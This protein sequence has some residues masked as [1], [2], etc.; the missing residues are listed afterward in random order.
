M[1]FRRRGTCRALVAFSLV[2]AV[3]LGLSGT[4]GGATSSTP[5]SVRPML[6]VVAAAA[7]PPS[8]SVPLGFQDSVAFSG[9]TNPTALRFA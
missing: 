3:V 9:L 7:P 1:W 2:C 5:P 8:A 4:R 6:S